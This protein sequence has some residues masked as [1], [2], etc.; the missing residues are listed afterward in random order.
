MNEVCT[1]NLVSRLRLAVPENL[2]VGDGNK[3][4]SKISAI[5]GA[6]VRNKNILLVRIK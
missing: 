4:G 1:S 6:A 5:A 2:T 3:Y